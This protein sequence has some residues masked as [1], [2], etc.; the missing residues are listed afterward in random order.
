MRVALWISAGLWVASWIGVYREIYHWHHLAPSLRLN[1][2]PRRRGCRHRARVGSWW[3][4][5]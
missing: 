5:W 1:P 3:R 2:P 4:S